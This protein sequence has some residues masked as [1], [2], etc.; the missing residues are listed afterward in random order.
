MQV[1]GLTGISKQVVD[2]LVENGGRTIEIRS[3]HNLAS[4]TRVEPGDLIFVTRHSRDDLTPGVEGVLARVVAKEF[5]MRRVGVYS[6]NEVEEQEVEVA[7]LKLEMVTACRAA[8][9]EVYGVVRETIFYFS[10]R[11]IECW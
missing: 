4:A 8:K 2:D 5:A 10:Q 11:V 7:R 1:F 6:V 9:A 3:S